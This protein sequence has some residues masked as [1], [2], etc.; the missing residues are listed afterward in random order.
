MGKKGGSIYRRRVLDYVEVDTGMAGAYREPPDI[1]EVVEHIASREQSPGARERISRIRVA[2]YYIDVYGAW[3]AVAWVKLASD[4]PPDPLWWRPSVFM[5]HGVRGSGKSTFLETI[6]ML[7][8]DEGD[9][10]TIVDLIG[11]ADGENLAWLA[12]DR[13]GGRIL[14]VGDG[15][16]EIRKCQPCREKGVEVVLKSYHELSVG[17][18]VGSRLVINCPL[19]YASSGGELEGASH[20]LK[21]LYTQEI[22][23]AMRKKTNRKLVYTLIREAYTVMYSRLKILGHEQLDVKSAAIYMVNQARHMGM[24]MGLDT[25][26][27]KSIDKMVRM[28]LDA[29]VVKNVGSLGMLDEY[30]WALSVL[31]AHGLRRME[32]NQFAIVY[33][34]GHVGVGVYRKPEWHMEIGEDILEKTGIELSP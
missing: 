27:G 20:I 21:L 30:S 7:I 33:P 17:D 16:V 13:L 10:T 26:Y 28:S 11:S 12:M 34:A 3:M 23:H 5:V 8:V 25:I 2:G 31:D 22:L 18:I 29:L 19:L 15:S 1:V 24:V 9:N 6:G 14:L 32:K 4:K